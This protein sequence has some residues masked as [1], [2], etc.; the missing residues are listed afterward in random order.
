M[1]FSIILLTFNRDDIL[2]E[3]FN[4]LSKVVTSYKGKCEVILVDNNTDGKDRSKYIKQFNQSQYL[5]K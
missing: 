1:K 2:D 3:Q 4:H 5:Q